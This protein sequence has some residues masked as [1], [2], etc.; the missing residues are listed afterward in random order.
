M[1]NCAKSGRLTSAAMVH[2]YRLVLHGMLL[3]SFYLTMA[4]PA[5]ASAPTC[6]PA[7][8]AQQ[9]VAD[10]IRQ[11]YAA[12]QTDDLALFQSLVTPDYYAFDLGTRFTAE[13][14]MGLIKTL[15]DQGMKFEWTVNDPEV[16]VACDQAWLTYTNRGSVEAAGV[17]TPIEWLESAVLEYR[18][19]AWRIRFFHSTRVPPP[20]A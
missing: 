17:R 15:H 2:P 3:L 14:L 12:A 18:E 9:Q 10:V 5:S 8:G 19:G 1:L 4:A 20:K 6:A 11:M 7:Q 13:S 16:H